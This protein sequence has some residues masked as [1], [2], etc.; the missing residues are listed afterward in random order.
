MTIKKTFSAL[1]FYKNI[2]KFWANAELELKQKLQ[3][4]IFH[5]GV[6]FNKNRLLNRRNF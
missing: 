2:L 4:I 5:K 1:S 6:Y 3:N